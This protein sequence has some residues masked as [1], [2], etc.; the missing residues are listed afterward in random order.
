MRSKRNIATVRQSIDMNHNLEKSVE[1]EID[2]SDRYATV[3]V[4]GTKMD[5]DFS[6]NEEPEL[7]YEN[8]KLN[9]IN[10]QNHDVQSSQH[11]REGIPQNNEVGT[12]ISGNPSSKKDV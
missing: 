9:G 7:D 11:D 1:P 6:T 4:D 12:P 5:Q 10:T 2:Q 3:P 8:S